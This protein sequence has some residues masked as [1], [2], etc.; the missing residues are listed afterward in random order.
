MQTR[1]LLI[2]DLVVSR[3][4]DTDRDSRKVV[5]QPPASTLARD[6]VATRRALIDRKCLFSTCGT[7]RRTRF[8]LVIGIREQSR[9][10]EERCDTAGKDGSLNLNLVV[11]P[12]RN[13]SPSPDTRD[14]LHVATTR[15]LIKSRVKRIC[16][17]VS[18]YRHNYP[19][20]HRPPEKPY[21][22]GDRTEALC[23]RGLFAV[24]YFHIFSPL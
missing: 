13:V 19:R 8:H 20:S 23:D 7:R 9:A 24:H 22:P 15:F 1:T 10:R 5:L 18:I 21:T 6:R 2:Q 4:C 3:G 17:T 14:S 12:V 11:Y 16:I